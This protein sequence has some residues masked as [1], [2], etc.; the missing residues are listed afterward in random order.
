MRKFFLSFVCLAFLL[1]GSL[2]AQ[3]PKIRPPAIP[4]GFARPATPQVQQAPPVRR[5]KPQPVKP[6]AAPATPASQSGKQ[7]AES[8]AGSEKVQKP[9]ETGATQ[10]DAAE[11]AGQQQP[12]PP[13]APAVRPTPPTG[14]L[15][16]ENAALTEVID[17]LCRQLKINYILDP[18]VEGGVILNTCSDGESRRHLQDRSSD[19]G[20]A[21][22][23]PPTDQSDIDSRR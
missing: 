6:A 8:A 4:P 14:A 13:P 9:S 22:S 16:L 1:A 23:H 5:R 7:S 12:A 10:A 19:G 17:A 15:N 3:K 20:F 11:A 2:E 21:P 18:R